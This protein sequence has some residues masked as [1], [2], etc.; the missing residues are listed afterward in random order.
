VGF[1]GGDNAP[2]RSLSFLAFIKSHLSG[3]VDVNVNIHSTQSFD[4]VLDTFLQIK[5]LRRLRLLYHFIG[6]EYDLG[7]TSNSTYKSTLVP[8]CTDL[9]LLNLSNLG[10]EAQISSEGVANIVKVC[11]RS[12]RPEYQA[13]TK[14]LF[15]K[16][17]HQTWR[18][19]TWVLPIKRVSAYSI[20]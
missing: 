7:R 2:R 12:V 1:S 4:T 18:S 5:T 11:N 9:V 10:F 13:I 3:L 8:Q 16:R 14:S 17:E 15:T 19:C 20:R 6:I